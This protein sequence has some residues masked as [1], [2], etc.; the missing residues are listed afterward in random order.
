LLDGGGGGGP[1]LLMIF[2]GIT[3][4]PKTA[5]YRKTSG[6]LSFFSSFLILHGAIVI[7]KNCPISR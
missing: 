2:R 5:S 6:L 3:G 4:F 1:S 7:R